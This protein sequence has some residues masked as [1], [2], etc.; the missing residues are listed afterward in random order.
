MNAGP[1]GRQVVRA[2]DPRA[3]RAWLR[4]HHHASPG[5]WLVISK[6]GA[7][8]PGVTYVEAVEEALCFGWIDST[9]NTLDAEHYLLRLTPRK[10]KS[11][12]SR[13]NKERIERLVREGRMT[14]AGMRAIETA[15]ANG[16]W[17]ELDPVD[18]LRV[19]DDL[20][21]AFTASPTARRHFERFPPSVRK[22]ILYWIQSAKRPGT[23]ARR[24]EETVRLAAQNRRA[25]FDRD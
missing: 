23:R 19:P 10:P 13:I 8:Q 11:V 12:W 4:R 24:I 15:K 14:D 17:A 7:R 1:D 6:K 3:W 2:K 21:A 16:S 22:P 20:A 25:G 18:D 9:P 5:V